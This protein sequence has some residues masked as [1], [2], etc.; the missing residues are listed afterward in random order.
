[1][2][3]RDE[4]LALDI[5]DMMNGIADPVIKEHAGKIIKRTGD[6]LMIEFA[7][8]LAAAQ[9]AVELQKKLKEHNSI[10][11][12][13]RRIIVRIGIHSGDVV[14]GGPGTTDLFGNTVNIA[15]R[16]EPHAPGG[17]IAITESVYH[18]IASTLGMPIK[19]LGTFALKG[20]KERQPLYQIVLS[21]AFYPGSDSALSTLKLKSLFSFKV[22]GTVAILILM[23]SIAFLGVKLIKN[24]TSLLKVAGVPRSSIAV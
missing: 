8:A 1:M 5:V 6:G 20:I 2:T 10:C 15:A 22:Y 3:Q 7:S 16:V 19:P 24:K 18:Q 11:P 13:E 12:R 17:G 14:R 4:H 21:K 9:C 23:I